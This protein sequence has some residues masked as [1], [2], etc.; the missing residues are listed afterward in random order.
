MPTQTSP[1]GTAPTAARALEHPAAGA[2][3]IEE[4]LHA[5]SDPIRLH[6]VRALDTAPGEL[7]CSDFALPISKST[8]THHF[9]V[10]RECGVISQFYRGTAKMN[11]LRRAE[12][13]EL[14]PGLLDSVL[15]GAARQ[16]ARDAG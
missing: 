3:R 6:V 11:L 5:L 13:D 8:C 14:F 16:D 1:P 7:S 9:R 12:L 2:I 15:H 4:L 10:L